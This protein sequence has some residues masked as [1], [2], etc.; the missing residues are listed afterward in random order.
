MLRELFTRLWKDES[1]A[2][3][4]TEYLMLGTIVG[5]GGA[6]GLAAMQDGMNQ[7]YVEFGSAVRETRQAYSVPGARGAAGRTH[8]TAAV[9]TPRPAVT[10]F[11]PPASPVSQDMVMISAP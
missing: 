8:G 3:I 7:E 10:T 6:S 9:D 5:L 1:G 4:A 11:V 2:V